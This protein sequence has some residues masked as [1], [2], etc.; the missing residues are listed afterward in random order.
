MT[1]QIDMKEL[2]NPFQT[3][4]DM[5]RIKLSE[6][7]QTSQNNDE[8]AFRKYTLKYSLAPTE[9]TDN[10]NRFGFI[11]SE[12]DPI[13]FLTIGGKEREYLDNQSPQ[14]IV[15]FSLS[16]KQTEIERQVYSIFTLIGDI[17]GF[18]SAIIILPTFVMAF[19]SGRMFDASLQEE[20]PT[21]NETSN[22]P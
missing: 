17:G 14:F 4:F 13:E 22:Q 9:F 5:E 19:Y 2:D 21:R 20:I 3:I 10:S 6:L 11:A 18:N 16:D 7:I 8:K 12:A 1:S 15:E